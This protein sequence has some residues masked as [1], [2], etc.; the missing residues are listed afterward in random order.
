MRWRSRASSWSRQPP[1]VI[2]IRAKIGADLIR[3]SIVDEYDTEF[4]VL[5]ASSK[6]PLNLAELI[7]MI[8]RAD[9]DGESLGLCFTAA[10]HQAN[11]FRTFEETENFTRVSSEFYPQLGRYYRALV[12]SW[13]QQETKRSN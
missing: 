12:H 6:R 10:N 2:S 3:Y 11:A 7:K 5:P 9:S 4:Q 1:T 8:D 13:Y